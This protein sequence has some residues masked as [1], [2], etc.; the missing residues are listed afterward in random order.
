[1]GGGKGGQKA[2]GSSRKW[3]VVVV[4]RFRVVSSL[5]LALR[6]GV[7]EQQTNVRVRRLL[8]TMGLERVEAV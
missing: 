3:V 8:D 6:F 4:G 7:S 1:M 5:E 2:W